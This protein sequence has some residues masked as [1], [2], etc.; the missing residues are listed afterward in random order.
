MKAAES[1]APLVAV[2]MAVALPDICVSLTSEDRR[3]DGPRYRD[4]CAN[5]LKTD[6]FGFVTPEDLYSIRC[7]VLHNGRFGGLCH[8]VA[9]VIFTLPHVAPTM[10]NCKINDAWVYSAVEFCRNLCQAAHDWSE[11]NRDHPR[12]VENLPHLMQYR[13]GG[14][15]PYI[16]GATVLA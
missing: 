1:G 14:L 5:N 15:P 7:G 10:I 8:S 13:D 3:S 12:M 11:K 4:W 6:Y 9:R 16:G 2:S